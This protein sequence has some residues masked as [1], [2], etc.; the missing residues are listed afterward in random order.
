MKFDRLIGF[1]IPDPANC[2]AAAAK[3][4]EEHPNLTP[5]QLAH[6]AVASARRMAAGSGAALGLMASPFTFLPAA[7]TDAAAVLKIEGLMAG[8][9]AALLDPDV[10]DRADEF[11]A[12]VLSIIFPG[13]ASQA[14]RAGGVRAGVQ[15]TQRLIR[16]QGAQRFLDSVLKIGGR[17]FGRRLVEKALM[18]KAVPI[19][20]AGIGGGWNWLEVHAVGQRAVSYYLHRPIGPR[21]RGLFRSTPST[22]TES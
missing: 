11:R 6:K 8:T 5:E 13:L 1:L 2:R 18:T 12:D 20:G 3:L 7:V 10:L 16:S 22:P 17:S 19:I 21:R 9:I 15:I 14:L 4:R